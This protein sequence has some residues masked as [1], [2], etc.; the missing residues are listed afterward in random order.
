M[1]YDCNLSSIL[2]WLMV[3]NAFDKSIKAAPTPIFML[4]RR[5]PFWLIFSVDNCIV[6]LLAGC[7]FKEIHHLNVYSLFKKGCLNSCCI[8]PVIVKEQYE[9]FQPFFPNKRFTWR[10]HCLFSRP[11]LLCYPEIM[12]T[13]FFGWNI[14]V[15]SST[16][17][18]K[19]QRL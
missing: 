14:L 1:L 17:N 11:A 6:Y 7:Y 2:A 19:C 10:V 15:C 4:S 13:A 3:S 12:S 18:N 5:K 8:W 9:L 16:V